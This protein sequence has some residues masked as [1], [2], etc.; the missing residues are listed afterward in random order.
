M[1]ASSHPRILRQKT[2]GSE[3]MTV[4]KLAVLAI[5]AFAG[6]G[7]AACQTGGASASAADSGRDSIR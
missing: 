1:R 2:P 4:H 6:F 3:A 7:L 5:S